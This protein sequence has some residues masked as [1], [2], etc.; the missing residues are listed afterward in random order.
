M[1]KV[2][3]SFQK[4]M[5][6]SALIFSQN[7]LADWQQTISDQLCQQWQEISAHNYPCQVTFPSL[8][9]QYQLPHCQNDQW[10]PQLTRTLKPG[11]NGLILTCEHPWWQQNFAV[12]LQVMAKIAVLS[13][14]VNLGNKLTIQDITFVE[15][16]L[17]LM[18][19]D[20]VTEADQVI[21]L[22][23]RRSQR[24]GTIL[25]MDML[26]VPTLIQRGDLITI[27][28]VRT[29]VKVE[30][31]GIALEHGKLGQRI[32]VRNSQSQNIVAAKV[33]SPKL[34]QVQ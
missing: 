8:S 15:H 32:R 5:I 7:S 34:V 17:G 22:Q 12:H 23:I 33:I 24:A 10:Q 13:Q 21:G 28:I 11:R 14:P 2:I 6:F 16:D 9:S 25:A 18:N 30:I 27:R 20:Y 26:E 31:Q 29:G 19:K 1:S 4:L 3:L